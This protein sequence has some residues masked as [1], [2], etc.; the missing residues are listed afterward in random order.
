M[1]TF[2]QRLYNLRWQ[3]W[4]EPK[5]SAA[6]AHDRTERLSW[7]L[8]KFEKLQLTMRSDHAYEEAE[9]LVVK[10]YGQRLYMDYRAFAQA[11]RRYYGAR[12]YPVPP[13]A[14][15]VSLRQRPIIYTPERNAD[16]WRWYSQAL[17]ER[18]ELKTPARKKHA[19]EVAER[20]YMEKYGH[21]RYSTPFNAAQQKRYYDAK[22]GIPDRPAR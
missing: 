4:R 17:N 10:K 18:P 15:A 9:K 5:D 21:S 11:R 2:A 22:Q 20:K 12:S 8:E 14:F 19:W 7:M 16:Y 6:R 3:N 1:T 13:L